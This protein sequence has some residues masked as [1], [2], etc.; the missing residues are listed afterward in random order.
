MTFTREELDIMVEGAS[1]EISKV[2]ETLE[3]KLA[4][5]EQDIIR[6][7]QVQ[8]T[9]PSNERVEVQLNKLYQDVQGFS[10]CLK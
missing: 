9:L 2:K 1:L 7:S 3:A 8:T 6:L 5:K 4:K 10:Q